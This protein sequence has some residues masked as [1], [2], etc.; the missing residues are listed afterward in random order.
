L[1]IYLGPG[2]QKSILQAFHTALN[3]EGLL[4]PG[5]PENVSVTPGLFE[6]LDSYLK[7]FRST[8]SQPSASG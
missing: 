4:V 8:K 1:L 5:K 6:A 7:I 3:P 2:I